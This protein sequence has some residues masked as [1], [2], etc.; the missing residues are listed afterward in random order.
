ML[1]QELAAA[2]GCSTASIKYYRREGLLPPGTRLTATRQEY[3]PR[4]LERLE[5]IRVLREMAD[6]PIPRIR[7]LAALLDDPAVP[8]IAALEEAQAITL[9][10]DVEPA[11]GERPRD[12][13]PSV[14]VM[15]ERLGWPDIDSV[16]RRA[17]D[18]LVRTLERWEMPSDP[19]TLLHYAEPM[20]QIARRELEYLRMGSAAGQEPSDDAVVLRAVSGTI[21]FDR[22]VHVLRALGHTSLS[23]QASE[24]PR[25]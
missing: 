11:G 14:A 8:L 1:L 23:V 19:E 12:E 5:L 7:R 10:A 4:H 13:H 15:L 9:G 25:E 6:A 2:S 16:P 20:G 17:L 24:L 21:A 18:A 3:G 22:L